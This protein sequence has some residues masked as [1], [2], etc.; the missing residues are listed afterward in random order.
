MNGE[1]REKKLVLSVY[2]H[3]DET[4]EFHV[5]AGSP[6]VV[7]AVAVQYLHHAALIIEESGMMPGASLMAIK[8]RLARETMMGLLTAEVTAE[9]TEKRPAA[10]I[11][12][13]ITHEERLH[14]HRGL[15]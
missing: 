7:T 4:Y 13:E 8:L 9:Q 10:E 3:D 15:Q 1:P 14:R 12:D 11:E 6:E 2:V 5:R